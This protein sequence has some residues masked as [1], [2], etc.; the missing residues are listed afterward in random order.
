MEIRSGSGVPPNR[1]LRASPKVRGSKHRAAQGRAP[2]RSGAAQVGRRAGR[3]GRAGPDAAQ[4]GPGAQVGDSCVLNILEIV[5]RSIESPRRS[6]AQVGPGAQIVARSTF[7]GR[8]RDCARID[9]YAWLA[10]VRSAATGRR[11]AGTVPLF[12]TAHAGRGRIAAIGLVRRFVNQNAG[13]Y[14]SAATL[15]HKV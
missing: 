9:V 6:A 3:A 5:A 4:V 15:L 10:G 1:D 11:S 14:V 8:M 7:N 2:R 13:F 12:G